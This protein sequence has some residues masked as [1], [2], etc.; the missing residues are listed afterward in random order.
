MDLSIN[1]P[2]IHCCHIYK[3]MNYHPWPGTLLYE[4]LKKENLLK[5][6]HYRHQLGTAELSFVHPH[7]TSAE[8][9]ENLLRQVFK[10]NYTRND[11]AMVRMVETTVAGYL[12][13]TQNHANLQSEGLTWNPESLTYEKTPALI[14]I[15]SCRRG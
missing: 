10:D 14:S 15:S 12:Q 4:D 1:G 9:H 6:V 8:D 13:A 7:F 11:L 5:E 3:F 2:Q